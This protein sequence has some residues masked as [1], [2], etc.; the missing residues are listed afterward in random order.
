[1]DQ[2][3]CGITPY[4][5]FRNSCPREEASASNHALSYGR[6][7]IFGKIFFNNFLTQNLN[8]DGIFTMNGMKGP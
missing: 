4:R 7:L 1:M 6:S 8:E 2:I 3:A 5:F